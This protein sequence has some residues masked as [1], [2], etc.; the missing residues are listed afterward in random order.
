MPTVRFPSTNAEFTPEQLASGGAEIPTQ[1]YIVLLKDSDAV[2]DNY[3]TLL[4]SFNAH[5][6]ISWEHRPMFGGKILSGTLDQDQVAWLLANDGGFIKVIEA[7]GEVGI[8]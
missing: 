1:V 6:G 7:D 4:N 8:A 3:Q 2:G 5:F